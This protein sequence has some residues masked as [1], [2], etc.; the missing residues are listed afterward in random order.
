MSV[1]PDPDLE[2][3][4]AEVSEVEDTPDGN[5]YNLTE[6]GPH[7]RDSI[8]TITASELKRVVPSKEE[9]RRVPSLVNLEAHKVIISV[10]LHYIWPKYNDL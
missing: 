1:N 4:H 8:F 5:V 2:I 10:T 3:Q 9:L 7:R 6:D